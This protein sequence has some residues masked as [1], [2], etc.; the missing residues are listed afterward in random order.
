MAA[1]P[2][3]GR[4]TEFTLWRMRYTFIPIIRRITSMVPRSATLVLIVLQRARGHSIDANNG[5][6]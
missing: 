4:V 1:R 6:G 2:K 5:N 3:S